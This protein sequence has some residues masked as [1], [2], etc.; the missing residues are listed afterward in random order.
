MDDSYIVTLKEE[1][2]LILQQDLPS[3]VELVQGTEGSVYHLN[4]VTEGNKDDV[5]QVLTESLDSSPGA[6]P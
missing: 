3:G 2:V 6:M 1:S 4:G 5:L